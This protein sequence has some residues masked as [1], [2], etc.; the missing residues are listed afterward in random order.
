MGQQYIETLD[1]YGKPKYKE[2]PS[3]YGAM[4]KKPPTIFADAIASLI[5]NNQYG[6]FYY[7]PACEEEARKMI[8]SFKN[9]IKE[10]ERKYLGG[11]K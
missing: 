10:L 8:K 2:Y 1:F 6:V 7:E 9:K 5:F 11:K 3:E 4:I